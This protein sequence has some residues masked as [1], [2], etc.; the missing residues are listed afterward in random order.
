MLFISDLLIVTPRL[1]ST[2]L[3]SSAEKN[4]S[5]SSLANIL[6]TFFNVS[7]SFL[8]ISFLKV[9][10]SKVISL[11]ARPLSFPLLKSSTRGSTFSFFF[12][13]FL[14][15]CYFISVRIYFKLVIFIIIIHKFKYSKYH[16][17]N[18][19]WAITVRNPL[20]FLK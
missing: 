2:L 14:D 9:S 19:F 15:L 7:S 13:F 10:S 6:N 18:C 1:S 5:L 3:T 16:F 12:F 8:W 17:F 4:F 20:S 11:A